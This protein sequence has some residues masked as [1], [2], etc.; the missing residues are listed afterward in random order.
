VEKFNLFPDRKNY[1]QA[2]K[3][4]TRKELAIALYQYFLNKN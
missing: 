3:E 1:L 2:W 4:L